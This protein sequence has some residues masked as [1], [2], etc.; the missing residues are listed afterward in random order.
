MKLS[1]VKVALAGALLSAVLCGC[2]VAPAPGYYADVAV[3]EVAPPA[4]E[5]EV[6]GVAPAPGYIWIGGAWFWEG[7]SDDWHSC[8]WDAPRPVFRWVTHN[9]PRRGN[10]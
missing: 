8:R 3:T 7:G 4:P 6:V 2:I 5:Y 9:T 10:N 1:S